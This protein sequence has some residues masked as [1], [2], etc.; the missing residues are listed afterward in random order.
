MPF[1]IDKERIIGSAI[2]GVVTGGII[3]FALIQFAF[4]SL[5]K[6]VDDIAQ[7]QNSLYQ[8]SIDTNKEIAFLKGKLQA[9]DF[10]EIGYV[11]ESPLRKPEPGEQVM[12]SA[13]TMSID[14]T[15][16]SPEEIANFIDACIHAGGSVSTNGFSIRNEKNMN[17][18]RRIFTCLFDVFDTDTSMENFRAYLENRGSE[19]FENNEEAE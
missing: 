14:A 12:A 17:I 10:S 4:K 2:A 8:I 3:S 16:L 1:S 19:I 11:E 18:T 5:E 7:N 9:V 6:R 13:R 15:V